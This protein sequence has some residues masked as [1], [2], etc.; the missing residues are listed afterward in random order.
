MYIPDPIE[1]LEREIERRVW[2]LDDAEYWANKNVYTEDIFD[3]EDFYNY[4][5]Y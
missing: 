1:L 2:E 5:R 3:N 4:P